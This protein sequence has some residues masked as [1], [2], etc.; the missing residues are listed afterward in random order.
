[1][2]FTGE[3][4]ALAKVGI[5]TI[6]RRKEVDYA[7]LAKEYH[8]AIFF[9]HVGE[10]GGKRDFPKTIGTPENG[11]KYF[12]IDQLHEVTAG[13]ESREIDSIHNKIRQQ[14]PDGF[15]LWGI[16]S[17]ARSVIS[18]LRDGDWLLLL[19][20]DGPGGQFYYGG[21][22][23]YR[24]NREMFDLSTRL[25]GEPRFPL[26]V[27]LDGKLTNFS[28][29]RFRDAFGYAPNWR[30]A[31]NTYRLTQERI[32]RSQFATEDDVI[33]AILG[34][35]GVS[36]KAN[37]MADEVFTDLMDQVELLEPSLEGRKRL[38]EH[39]ISERDPAL[40][41]EFK[42][43]LRSFSCVVCKFV[44]FRCTEPLGAISLKH[45]M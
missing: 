25:W 27:L 22:V 38:R 21:K 10:R 15:Q 16:P 11:L 24:P 45:T 13:L 4:C 29:E 2:L 33:I 34:I 12:Q 42:K 14:S 36:H 3:T 19:E 44:F 5:T 32:G 43:R 30:L 31:G 1:M 20:S 17:G 9:Q 6:R 35:A 41:R 40:I 18:N 7:Q 28:W 23:V 26:I 8:M 37:E 39:L